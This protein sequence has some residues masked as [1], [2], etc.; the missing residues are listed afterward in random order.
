MEVNNKA[1]QVE[2][3]TDGSNYTTIAQV[4]GNGST[5]SAHHYTYLHSNV[6][7]DVVYYRLNQVDHDGK[8]EL[9]KVIIVSK[10]NSENQDFSVFP[11]P[12]KGSDLYLSYHHFEQEPFSIAIYD[13]NEKLHY[14]EEFNLQGAGITRL[15]MIEQQKLAAGI[16]LVRIKTAAGLKNLKL[17]VE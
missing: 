7:A 9:S 12:N 17:V 6:E 14:S 10:L 3:S 1:F 11:N 8:S 5:N 16:Y 15:Y 4:E 13:M 2:M